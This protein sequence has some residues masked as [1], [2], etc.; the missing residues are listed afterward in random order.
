MM[1]ELAIGDAYGAGLEYTDR[2]NIE[3][4]NDLSA[5]HLHPK[6]HIGNGKYTDDTQM[7][8]AIA[9][10]LIAGKEWSRINLA[11][12]FVEV[13]KR[14]PRRGYAGGFYKFLK[15]VK[16]G[17]EFLEKIHP[18]SDKSGAAMRSSPI[19]IIPSTRQVIE[20]ATI[21]A[22]ITHDT[23]LGINAAIASA[24]MAHYF[25][26]HLGKKEDLGKFL[27]IKVAGNWD[28]DYLGEVGAKGYM[29]VEAAVS[30]IKQYDSLSSILKRCVDF[31]GDVDTVAAIAM[32]A[33]SCSSEIKQDLP[34]NL[35]MRLENGRY[36]RNYLTE[37]DNKLKNK[38]GIKNG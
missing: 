34:S 13:F 21:Q 23:H 30:A 6:W 10:L 37:I 8:I 18:D 5:Y 28:R 2:T 14:D 22:K 17:K 26:Y 25:I 35:I 9:E 33:A 20:Y 1:L 4:L 27:E 7:S 19:G 31:G 12:K 38:F 3:R 16:T 32:G 15:E 24:L 11:N 36:G 29:S